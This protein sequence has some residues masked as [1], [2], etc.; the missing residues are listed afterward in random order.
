MS[1]NYYYPQTF[2][3]EC[4]EYVKGKNLNIYTNNQLETFSDEFDEEAYHDSEAKFSEKDK[5]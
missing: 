1:W 5:K 4:K 2:S 3:E